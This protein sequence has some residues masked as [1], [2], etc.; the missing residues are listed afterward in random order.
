[1]TAN[2]G[3]GPRR[4]LVI[5]FHYPPDN[6]STG[7]LRTLKFTE[8]LADHG[9]SS[10]V[11]SVPEDLYE[12]RDPALAA[13]IPSHVNVHRV[14]AADVKRL[15]GVRGVYP[16]ALAF[17]D[18][19]WP[20]WRAAVRKGAELIAAGRVD[21]V[22]STYPM[23]TAHLIGLRLHRRFGLPWVADFRDPWIE[24]SMPRF[25]RWAEGAIERR[26]MARAGRV[27]CNT[28]AMCQYLRGRYPRLPPER[29]VTIT[30]GYDEKDFVD[31]EPEGID[32]FEIL[33]PG[34]IDAVNR[35]PLPLL[36]AVRLA[37]ERGWLDRNDLQVTLLGG[38]PYAD[39]ET[40]RRALAQ[41]GV[42]DVVSVQA[43]RMPYRR[44]LQRMAGADLLLALS[45]PAGEDARARR[46]RTWT[47]M[48]V[49]A[50]TYEY[51]RVGRK[52][53]ALMSG[54][55]VAELLEQTLG[56][57]TIP[58]HDIEAV[59]QALRTHYELR[60]TEAAAVPQSEPLPQVEAYSRERLTACL[61]AELE[62]I[63]TGGPR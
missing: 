26:V 61:A 58:P 49:P 53:L 44:A 6:S 16:Q 11:I 8:Y 50:K 25:R 2:P 45:E 33:Y 32:R 7:V 19:Y 35:D 22:Y 60:R 12:S 13:A 37:L 38:G 40:F 43:G 47:Y 15:L 31:L 30:N 23:A 20:W 42:A 14:W 28:P 21:A 48:Q 4:L 46:N 18:R 3:R 34:A 41:S 57:A 9:W 17:P 54:G 29:F 1:M 5:A 24:D 59:A 27:I 10:E 62:R 39:T 36:A 56:L 63:V 51:L 52:I 55:A